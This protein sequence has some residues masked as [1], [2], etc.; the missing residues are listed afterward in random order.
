MKN[1]S[2]ILFPLTSCATQVNKTYEAITVS[3]AESINPTPVNEVNQT[4]YTLKNEE[5]K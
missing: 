2:L 5:P 4:V 3:T 1:L